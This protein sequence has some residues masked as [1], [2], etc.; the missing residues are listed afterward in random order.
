MIKEL[1]E[2]EFHGDRIYYACGY[3]MASGAVVYK[4]FIYIKAMKKTILQNLN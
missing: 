2:N 4:Q 1:E 3:R